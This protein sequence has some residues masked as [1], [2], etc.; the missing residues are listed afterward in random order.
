MN[1]ITEGEPIPQG[2]YIKVPNMY[3]IHRPW[4]DGDRPEKRQLWF[5]IG[6]RIWRI[7][8][9]FRYRSWAPNIKGLYLI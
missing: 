9:M 5:T 8:G 3:Y 6:F 7:H 4:V 1:V 2:I